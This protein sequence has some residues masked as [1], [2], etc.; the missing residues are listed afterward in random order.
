MLYARIIVLLFLAFIISPALAQRGSSSPDPNQLNTNFPVSIGCTINPNVNAVT[1]QASQ[2]PNP[3]NH[4]LVAI[5]D[6]QS[7]GTNIIPTTY[8]PTNASA[9]LQMNI[10]DGGVYSISDPVLGTCLNAAGSGWS[11][12]Q[13]FDALITAGKFD[14][15]LVEPI[16]V[17]GTAVADHASGFLQGRLAT[18]INRLAAKG[19]VAGTNITVIV[20][21]M[22]GESDN[23]AG[24][25]QANY[26]STLNSLIAQSRAAGF[27]GP[28]FVPEETWDNGAASTAVQLAQTSVSPS[29]VINTSA[30][31]YPGPNL[32]ALVGSICTGSAA[33]RQADNTH[34]TTAARANVTSVWQTALHAAL[35]SIF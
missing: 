31:V 25:T 26:T 11:M 22:Q 8:T 10:G 14:H 30:S 21:W 17:D 28:W 29:G 4:Y 35:P 18:A 15:V 23:L 9:I 5:V 7:N 33:C 34:F 2:I 32:D 3:A 24:T 12:L 6:G 19:W 1:L 20:I 13:L 27:A 16:N